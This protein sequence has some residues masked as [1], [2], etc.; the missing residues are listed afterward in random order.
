V[1]YKKKLIKKLSFFLAYLTLR[2]PLKTS[3]HL[4]HFRKNPIIYYELFLGIDLGNIEMLKLNKDGVKES[5]GI[6]HLK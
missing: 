2:V 6:Y 1:E 3:A 4:A 5:I